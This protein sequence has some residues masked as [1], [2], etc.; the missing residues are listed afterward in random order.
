MKHYLDV[1]LKIMYCVM[2]VSYLVAL[3]FLLLF[4]P[5]KNNSL[6]G[7]DGARFD[8][9]LVALSLAYSIFNITS[10]IRSKGFI[11]GFLATCLPVALLLTNINGI[12]DNPEK[13]I[14]SSSLVLAFFELMLA[15][16]LLNY[17]SSKIHMKNILFNYVNFL[18]MS[19]FTFYLYFRSDLWFGNVFMRVSICL[20]LYL[21]LRILVSRFTGVNKLETMQVE[22][23][24]GI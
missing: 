2:F 22:L 8:L 21:G 20:S 10:K 9:I 14:E 5:L 4:E 13:L 15:L 17:M 7:M 12:Y 18:V 6:I 16:S 1:S 23:E 24:A 11:L 19:I 3:N